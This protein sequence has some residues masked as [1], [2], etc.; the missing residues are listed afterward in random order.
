VRLLIG[1]IVVLVFCS[2]SSASQTQWHARGKAIRG[3]VNGDG[4][5]EAVV[6]EQ[7]GHAC[8]FRLVAGSQKARLH[9]EICDEKPGELTSGPDP[10]VAVLAPI[11]GHRGLEIVVQLGHGAYMEFADFW[12]VRSG[13]LRRFAGRE[14]HLSWGSSAGTG[15]HVVDCGRSGVVVFSDQSYPPHGRIVR[16]WYS[17][18]SLRLNLLRTRSVNWNSDGAPPYHEFREPQPFPTCAQAR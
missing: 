5:A 14:P 2:A 3:D 12:T 17:A 11:D 4:Q 8:V 10:H 15:G 9:P 18:R 16:R 1:V 6:I 13:A 7:R